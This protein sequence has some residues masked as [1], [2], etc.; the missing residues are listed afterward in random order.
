MTGLGNAHFYTSSIFFL[1]KHTWFAGPGSGVTP[2]DPFPAHST[3]H[4]NLFAGFAWVP[5]GDVAVLAFQILISSRHALV[6]PTSATSISFLHMTTVALAGNLNDALH[7]NTLF[8]AEHI[9][10]IPLFDVVSDTAGWISRSEGKTKDHDNRIL[11]FATFEYQET[12]ELHG[13]SWFC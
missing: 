7:P 3:W 13:N 2:L 10:P 11:T 12:S 9:D 1:K 4:R 5:L 6:L 8:R